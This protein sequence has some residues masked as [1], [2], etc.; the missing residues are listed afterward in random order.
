M[1][2]GSSGR[3]SSDQSAVAY[4]SALSSQNDDEAVSDVSSGEQYSP[5][6]DSSDVSSGSPPE[7]PRYPS[8]LQ[9]YPQ[10]VRRTRTILTYESLGEPHVSE[11][12]VPRLPRHLR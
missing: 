11:Y 8:R 6:R 5:R 1:V 4:Q 7:R 2:A 12:R 10:R 3:D 9:R